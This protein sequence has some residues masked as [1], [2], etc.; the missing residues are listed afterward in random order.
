LD[1]IELFG[2]VLIQK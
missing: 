2:A 1:L